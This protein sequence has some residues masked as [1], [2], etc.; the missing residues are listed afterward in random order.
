[1][2]ACT[3][4]VRTHMVVDQCQIGKGVEWRYRRLCCDCPAG[5]LATAVAPRWLTA[6]KSACADSEWGNGVPA[7]PTIKR[8]AAVEHSVLGWRIRAG[9]S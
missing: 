5:W 1:M 6:T 4:G 9:P 3:R 2:R 7:A 8:Q